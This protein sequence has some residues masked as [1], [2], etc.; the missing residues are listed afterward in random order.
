MKRVIGLALISLLAD[1]L[2]HLGL[3]G[4]GAGCRLQG[5][6]EQVGYGWG[7]GYGDGRDPLRLHR[8]PGGIPAKDEP[9]HRRRL[10]RHRQPATIGWSGRP[11][12][13]TGEEGPLSHPT[14]AATG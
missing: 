9:L 4:R 8:P 11:P 12:G 5:P 14:T 1:R 10:V 13:C 2:H 3:F 6:S 7:L